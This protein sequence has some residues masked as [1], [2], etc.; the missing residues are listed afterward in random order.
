[1]RSTMRS[2]RCTVVYIEQHRNAQDKTDPEAVAEHQLVAAVICLVGAVASMFCPVGALAATISMLRVVASVILVR[3]CGRNRHCV[4]H[5][6]IA[7]GVVLGTMATAMLSMI[8]HFVVVFHNGRRYLQQVGCYIIL[9]DPC[10]FHVPSQAD[11]ARFQSSL[12][13]EQ[14]LRSF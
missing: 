8:H 4:A 14:L 10:P 3:E 2:P 6:V 11:L 5:T 13:P 12:P 9:G 7:M 1:M